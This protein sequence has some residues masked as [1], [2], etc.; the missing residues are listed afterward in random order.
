MNQRP[1]SHENQCKKQNN[2]G[3]FMQSE[4]MIQK[5]FLR[6]FL[7]LLLIIFLAG[8][9]ISAL[10]LYFDVYRPLSTEYSSI[11]SVIAEI[12]DSLIV[13]TAKIYGLFYLFIT[14]GIVYLVILYTHRIAGPLHRVKLQTKAIGEGRLDTVIKLRR[15][16][17]I[18]SFADTINDMTVSLNDRVENLT[19][20]IQQLRNAVTEMKSSADENKN[21]EHAL[22]KA[23]EQDSTIKSLLDSLRL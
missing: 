5:N 19:N 11:L 15:N 18:T 21:T 12:M 14:V 13:R 1:I 2:K 10:T 22:K 8:T 16:D 9:V 3:D 23:I 4:G 6:N 20:E 7:L 17:A